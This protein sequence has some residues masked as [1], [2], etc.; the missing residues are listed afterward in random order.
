[1]V[2]I[3]NR[4]LSAAWLTLMFVS[5][6]FIPVSLSIDLQDNFADREST[7][8]PT[9]TLTADNSRATIENREPRHANKRSGH[10]MWMTWVASADGI[11]T[12]STDGSDF[13]TVLAAYFV[14]PADGAP[15]L[16]RLRETAKADDDDDERGEIQF[17]V[18]QGQAYEIAVAGYDD[19]VGTIQLSWS[20]I[21]TTTIPPV[22]V[23][24][25]DDRSV[26]IGDPLTLS[27]DFDPDFGNGLTD[28]IELKWFFNDDEIEDDD[29]EDDE[30]EPQTLTIPSFQAENV[31]FYRLQMRV[32]D[33]RFFIASVEVQINS[34]GA[35]SVL[36][37]S[38]WLDALGSPLL[39]NAGFTPGPG[40]SARKLNV[41]KANVS[42]GFTGSQ[43]FNTIYARSQPGEPVHCGVPGG[44]SYWFAYEPP[45]DGRL[46]VNTQGSNFPTI[47]AVYTWNVPDPQFSDLVPLSCD[48][49]PSVAG[50]ASQV[51][52]DVENGQKL[53]IVVDG[54]QGATGIAYLNY[55]LDTSSVPDVLPK[56]LAQPE[57]LLV[58]L[59]DSFKLAVQVTSPDKMKFQWHK[60]NEPLTGATSPELLI[61]TSSLTDAGIYT[62]QVWNGGNSLI[63]EAARIVVRPKPAVVQSA[64]IVRYAPGKPLMLVL[65]EVPEESCC[66]QWLKNGDPLEGAT[67]HSLIIPA[68]G[69]ADAG[70]YQFQLITPLGSLV[71]PHVQV[72]AVGPLEIKLES[73]SDR[74]HLSWSASAG[75]DYVLQMAYGLTSNTWE[76]ISRGR[77]DGNTLTTPISM[78]SPVR[79]YRV[80]LP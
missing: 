15:T 54:F 69:I 25:P 66:F 36:A 43:I 33:I 9:G 38:K 41:T 53:A 57:S 45:S 20:F 46:V 8:D 65:D 48:H 30:D 68:A 3:H 27:V 2:S 39:A 26:R 13:D 11:V 67:S 22:V 35:V 72:Q 18:L 16:D 79:Y 21:S 73:D 75:V 55:S 47:L 76:T 6:T 37:R 71:S 12:F 34:E 40:S 50:P 74:V 42:R 64:G 78:E 80:L 61:P 51:T 56:I 44:S 29:D 23:S 62:V 19:E 32:D 58:G 52:I 17:G 60:D 10:S 24:F 49:V 31:G 63:S 70:Q 4:I 7:S 28:D 5:S 1:M 59:G 77:S 14:R